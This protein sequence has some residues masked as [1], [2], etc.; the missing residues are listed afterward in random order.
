MAKKRRVTRKKKRRVTRRVIIPDLPQIRERL[1]EHPQSITFLRQVRAADGTLIPALNRV[2]NRWYYGDGERAPA[3][4][5]RYYDMDMNIVRTRGDK[6]PS[7]INFDIYPNS[8]VSEDKVGVVVDALDRGRPVVV[9]IVVGYDGAEFDR[10]EYEA[11]GNTPTDVY[12]Q[13]FDGW[14]DFRGRYGHLFS[15]GGSDYDEENGISA[16]GSFA[17]SSVEPTR[18]PP[19]PIRERVEPPEP[20]RPPKKYRG[21][22]AKWRTN[23]D[24]TS[25]YY[26]RVGSAWRR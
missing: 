17:V 18:A 2:G 11:G 5:D 20:I 3:P 24:G 25:G 1:L 4:K 15:A 14:R 19:S 12:N 26:Y 10:W 21:R 7:N 13:L 6:L 8:T 9:E 16:V 23:Q 22:N